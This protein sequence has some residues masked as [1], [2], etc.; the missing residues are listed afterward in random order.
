VRLA[1]PLIPFVTARIVKTIL[2]AHG[3]E[4]WKEMCATDRLSIR[5]ASR[6]LTNS[7]YTL[8]RMKATAVPFNGVAC[9]LGLSVRTVLNA[10]PPAAPS[11]PLSL[12]A[13]DDRMRPIGDRV[14][15]LAARINQ[16]ERYK[17]HYPL[18]RVLPDV[19]KRHPDVQLVFPGSGDDHQG[20]AAYAR[21]QGIAASV[22]L[23]GYLSREA[24][25][26]LYRRC[27]AYVMPSTC[28]GFGLAHLE[29]MNFAKPCVGCFDDGAADV[30]RHGETGYL[31]RNPN[32]AGELTSVLLR[33]LDN[34]SLAE[35]MGLAGFERLHAYFTPEQFRGRVRSELLAYL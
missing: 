10:T 4:Y 13:C 32:D 20:I 14:L 12:N 33:L 31:V 7:N 19:M 35:K 28:E 5:F 22:F 18:M 15:L 9:T 24:L 16:S 26:D 30:I 29:A 27:Y 6:I 1:S 2:F 3:I 8:D 11:D 21:D 25:D 34:P 23:P 17:G